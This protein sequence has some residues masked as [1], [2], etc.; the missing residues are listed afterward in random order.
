MLLRR[1]GPQKHHLSLPHTSPVRSPS[2]Q[3][4]PRVTVTPHAPAPPAFHRAH[5]PTPNAALSPRSRGAAQELL[6]P[7]SWTL[8][9]GSI[10]FQAAA[11]RS[12]EEQIGRLELRFN[13]PLGNTELPGLIL[14]AEKSVAGVL[15]LITSCCRPPFA[16]VREEICC[17]CA[18]VNAGNP[19]RVRP[20][21]GPALLHLNLSLRQMCSG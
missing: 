17:G 15:M 10:L 12:A 2:Q 5:P 18:G 6:S 4:L 3:S 8:S 7:L 19:A 13:L 11:E 1:A 16:E 21:S 9:A 14:V 20:A